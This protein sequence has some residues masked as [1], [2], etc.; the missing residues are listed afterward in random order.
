MK[1]GSRSSMSKTKS[2][3]KQGKSFTK[4]R[5]RVIARKEDSGSD[6]EESEVTQL[7]TH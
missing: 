1:Q 7:T 5:P 4:L 2:I 6:G 3:T